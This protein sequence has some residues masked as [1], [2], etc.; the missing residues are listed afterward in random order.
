MSYHR[1]W[2]TGHEHFHHA[3]SGFSRSWTD[4]KGPRSIFPKKC[5]RKKA[6]GLLQR[7]CRAL[8]GI[9]ALEKVKK[10]K[11]KK[12]KTAKAKKKTQRAQSQQS[13]WECMSCTFKENSA[14]DT[15]CTICR[16]L[17]HLDES[18]ASMPELST[19][20][21]PLQAKEEPIL[22]A[23]TSESAPM[24]VLST[25]AMPL[26]AKEEP[27]LSAPTSV[28]SDSLPTNTNPPLTSPPSDPN[29]YVIFR[30]TFLRIILYNICVCRSHLKPTLIA[31]HLYKKVLVRYGWESS[32]AEGLAS[33]LKKHFPTTERLLEAFAS[34]KDDANSAG[35]ASNA[36]IEAI[37]KEFYEGIFRIRVY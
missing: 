8:V 9:Y 17:C 3:N 14:S 6:Q 13:T 2:V 15:E 1:G 34:F 20:A 27:M 19:T 18:D 4:A 25:T 32:D 7:F 11:E 28:L 12:E 26:Q 22:S 16:A 33:V 24:P 23:P 36:V 30:T 5:D 31:E 29:G 21:M 10:E 35:P 37:A